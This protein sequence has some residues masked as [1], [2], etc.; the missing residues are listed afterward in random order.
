MNA[1][2]VLSNLLLDPE[3]V[4]QLAE[5]G[6]LNKFYELLTGHILYSKVAYLP[7]AFISMWVFEIISL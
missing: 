1:L 7:L 2:L 6:G 4:E 5:S 3:T